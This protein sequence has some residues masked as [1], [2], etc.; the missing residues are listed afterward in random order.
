MRKRSLILAS[1]GDE[2]ESDEG[3]EKM[4]STIIMHTCTAAS[5]FHVDAEN[6][7]H[8]LSIRHSILRA[9]Q[10]YCL[11]H[12]GCKQECEMVHKG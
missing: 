10:V 4:S 5:Q 9:S 2:N 8:P 3:Y 6:L 11:V 7:L 12:Q 1:S